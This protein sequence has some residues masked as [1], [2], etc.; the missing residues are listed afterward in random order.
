LYAAELQTNTAQ[1]WRGCF[2]LFLSGLKDDD[3]INL[4]REFGVTGSREQLLKLF[5]AFGNYPLLIRALAGEI[6]EY[7]PAP[8]DFDRWIAKNPDFN[9]G[10]LD[11]KNAKSHVLEYALRGLPDEHR[12]VLHTIAAFRMPATWDTLRSLLVEQ[13]RGLQAASTPDDERTVK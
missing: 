8:G 1:P 9:P 12:K 5:N 6:A 4:W 7:K 2:A 3:A 10:Q 11:L 13:E